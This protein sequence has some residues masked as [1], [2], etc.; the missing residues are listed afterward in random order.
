[1][2]PTI[3]IKFNSTKV[4]CP[5]QDGLLYEYCSLNERHCKTFKH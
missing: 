1:M 2:D 5:S 4:F 3:S